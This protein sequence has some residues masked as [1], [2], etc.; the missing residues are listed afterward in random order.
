MISP[1][2]YPD[3]PPMPDVRGALLL[4]RDLSKAV[5]RASKAWN[6]TQLRDAMQSVRYFVDFIEKDLQ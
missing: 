5:Q 1:E 4:V 6:K 3:P 2:D